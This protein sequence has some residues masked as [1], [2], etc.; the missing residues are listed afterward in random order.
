MK[1][2]LTFKSL[3][4]NI[5]I[6]FV[7]SSCGGGSSSDSVQTDNLIVNISLN[8]LNN[9]S[10]SYEKQIIEVTS[11]I[12]QCMFNIALD[13]AYG[14]KIHHVITED[15]KNFSFRN[16][17]IYEESMDFKLLPYEFNMVDLARKE[18]LGEDLLFTKCGWIYQYNAI[19]NNKDNQ[20]TNYYMKK[21]YEHFYG[22]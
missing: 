12:P 4:K 17:I 1:F 9:S 18:L 10:A 6:I 16:P 22:E 11:N 15:N 14:Y 20:L 3:F 2:L 8:G 7:V 13:N 19:P 5:F 21:T